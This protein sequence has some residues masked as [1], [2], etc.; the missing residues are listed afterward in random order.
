MK[1]GNKTININRTIINDNLNNINRLLVSKLKC[2][3]KYKTLSINLPKIFYKIFKKIKSEKKELFTISKCISYIIVRYAK[4]IRTEYEIFK[5][6]TQFISFCLN[7]LLLHNK[8]NSEYLMEDK[9]IH[10]KY[11]KKA[12][13]YEKTN[14][15]FNSLK[16]PKFYHIT[17]NLIQ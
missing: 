5:N 8:L 13:E 16:K 2:C 10:T 3:I 17:K 15:V 11:I 7:D 4:L 14:Y 6:I 12:K 1:M 9:L